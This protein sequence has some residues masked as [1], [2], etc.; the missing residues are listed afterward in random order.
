MKDPL[1]TAGH[2]TYFD[3]FEEELLLRIAEDRRVAAINESL[4]E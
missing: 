1:G 3:L 2:S 4:A